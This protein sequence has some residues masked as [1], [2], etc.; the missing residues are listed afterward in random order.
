[1]LI[2]LLLLCAI[3]GRD[4]NNGHIPVVLK[5]GILGCILANGNGGLD[6]GEDRHVNVHEDEVELLCGERLKSLD[7]RG[8]EDRQLD[9][10]G[11]VLF[12]HA[13]ENGKIDR[14]IVDN[15][16]LDL[17]LIQL[18]GRVEAESMAVDAVDAHGG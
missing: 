9:N 1:M 2:E 17:A 16:D 13:R 7:T 10:V 11:K 4:S 12:E 18:Q 8:H 6:A 15:H 14:V 5:N 3:A